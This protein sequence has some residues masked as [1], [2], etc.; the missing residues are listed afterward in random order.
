MSVVDD[1]LTANEAKMKKVISHLKEDLASL[2]AGRATPALLNKITVDYYGAPTPINQ[3]A[4]VTVPEPRMIVITPWDK[5]MIKEL[6]R[7][8]M[9][10]DLGLNPNSDGACIRLNMP[11][12]TEERRKELVKTARKHTEEARVSIRNMRRDI[13]EG[14]KKA[15]KAKTITE[16]DST[17]GQDQAQ[18]LTDKMMK[19]VDKVIAAKEKEIMEV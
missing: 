1:L 7:A 5:T 6:S 10:S 16:D 4:N 17:D 2:R 18:K 12:L 19:E 15:E 3:V 8:I 11:M 13:I 14:I 9:A